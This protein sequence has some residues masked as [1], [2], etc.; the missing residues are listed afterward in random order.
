LTEFLGDHGERH[1]KYGG[2]ASQQK[3]KR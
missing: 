3:S 1:G 2:A